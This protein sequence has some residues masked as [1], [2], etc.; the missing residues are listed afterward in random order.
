VD[1]LKETAGLEPIEIVV[2]RGF[3]NI[4]HFARVNIVDGAVDFQCSRIRSR[5]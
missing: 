4:Q 1:V 5:R 2:H 3:G